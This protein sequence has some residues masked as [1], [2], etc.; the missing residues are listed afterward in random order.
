MCCCAN[1]TPTSSE[2]TIVEGVTWHP[3]AVCT[4]L[5]L[6][7]CTATAPRP[8]PERASSLLE[9]AS[10]SS[11]PPATARVQPVKHRDSGPI[12]VAI[13]VDQLAS[14]VANERLPLLPKHGGFARL[15]REGTWYRDV[16]FAHAITETAP[17]HASLFSG[18]VP[19]EHGIVANE[20]MKSGRASAILLDS[21]TKLVGFEGIRA[22]AGS[23]AAPL[24]GDV[25]ADRF[26]ARTPQGMVYSFSV[27]DRG[28]IFGGGH[29]PDLTLWF[30]VSSGGFVS[31]TAFTDKLPIWLDS[32]ASTSAIT[33]RIAQPWTLQEPRWVAHCITKDD[34]AGEGDFGNYGVGF[35]HRVNDANKPFAAYRINP[36]SDKLLLEMGLLALDHAPRGAPIFL[37]LSLSA[38][39]YIG[40]IFGPDSWEAWD[41][42]QRLDTSLA[43]FFSELDRRRGPEQWSVV[44][45]ADHGV[46][47]LPEVSR[48]FAKQSESIQTPV[49]RPNGVTERILSSD[50]EK[51]ARQ[52][53]TKALGTGIWIAGVVD[54]Y[55]YWSED[56]KRLTVPLRHR[57]ERAVAEG[58]LE[59]SSIA[60]LFDTATT[61]SPCPSG[62]D[63]SMDSLVCL[64]IHPGRGGDYFIALKQ[65]YFFDTGYVP[66]A[67][68][69]HGNAALYDRSVPLLERSAGQVQAGKVID[70]PQS[71]SLFSSELERLMGSR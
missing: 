64:S 53:A 48:A 18:K 69:S 60:K 11:I 41:E 43:W 34:Q 5:L 19:R 2:D 24:L 35:P 37:A 26:K 29:H 27:K 20:V 7:T 46:A 33:T 58:L 31:S 50:L 56:A 45:S 62:D 49:S 70:S 63:D 17:G 30:D 23:S 57:L 8:Q 15:M 3:P 55:L 54:P 47:L 21:G 38:N 44:L 9:G 10:A 42:L 59:Q 36:D 12:T 39:D 22:D 28:A 13:V 32:I 25:V 68:T 51:V 66:G 14:W 4:S 61:P 71:F 40:H 52:A 1:V 65:G 67:G 16:R 6:C